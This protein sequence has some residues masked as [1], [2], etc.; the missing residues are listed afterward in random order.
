MSRRYLGSGRSVAVRSRQ[1]PQEADD[2]RRH[3][4]T[5]VRSVPSR[6]RVPRGSVVELDAVTPLVSPSS[7]RLTDL[8]ALTEGWTHGQRED[9]ALR[10]RDP[11]QMVQPGGG[12]ADADAAAA[13]PR[14]TT[15]KAG[16]AGA[17]F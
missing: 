2:H 8:A 3:T 7:A 4:Q 9:S 16:N 10:E 1:E 14:R 11:A 17:G 13:R 5:I 12:F 6:C 15:D